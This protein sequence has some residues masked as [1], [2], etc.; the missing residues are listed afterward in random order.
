[1]IIRRRRI[2]LENRH[3]A[4]HRIETVSP[5]QF[6]REGERVA[7]ELEAAGGVV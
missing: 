2:S 1:M 3:R 7:L 6:V 4:R 5:H